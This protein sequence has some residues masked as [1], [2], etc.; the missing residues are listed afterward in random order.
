MPA[1]AYSTRAWSFCVREQDA[2]G[3]LSSAAIMFLVPAHVGVELADVLVAELFEFQFY[4]HVAL[5]DSVVED[6]VDESVGIAD[7]DALLPGLETEA[8][9]EFEQEFLHLSRSWS[10]RCD[11]LITSWG[12]RPRNSKI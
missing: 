9:A 5:Q 6:Q 3:G 4:Q 2:D 11:S 10:S 12:L 1:R 8:V 7:Q